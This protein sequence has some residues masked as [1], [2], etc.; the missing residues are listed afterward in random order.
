M[1]PGPF[2]RPA[3][4]A[5][6]L[7]DALQFLGHLL[8]GGNNRIERIRK[9]SRQ[10]GPGARKA[11]RKV[12]VPH[13]LQAGQDHAEVIGGGASESGLPVA[14]VCLVLGRTLGNG[15]R[16]LWAVFLHDIALL[17][18]AE[19]PKSGIIKPSVLNVWLREFTD[20]L[21]LNTKNRSMTL[22]SLL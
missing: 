8:I 18:V 1:K 15:G 19:P 14:L 7:P 12:A 2:S 17:E 21:G 20:C 10:S 22:G 13:A 3:L 16:H 9:L 4:L 11:H 6:D 5:H